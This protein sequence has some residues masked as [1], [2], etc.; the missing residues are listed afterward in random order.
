[1]KLGLGFSHTFV[2]NLFFVEVLRGLLVRKTSLPFK[3]STGSEKKKR[4]EHVEQPFFAFANQGNK[5]RFSIFL[6]FFLRKRERGCLWTQ[7]GKR[8]KEKKKP[9]A[10]NFDQMCVLVCRLRP[11]F[12]HWKV[13]W[14]WKPALKRTRVLSKTLNLEQSEMPSWYSEP[15]HCCEKIVKFPERLSKE[16]CDKDNQAADQEDDVKL[17]KEEH[18]AEKIADASIFP[19]SKEVRR[20]AQ[21]SGVE[22]TF[23]TTN[24]DRFHDS[25]K[26]LLPK[27]TQADTHWRVE[28]AKLSLW[29][30]P[31]EQSETSKTH[32]QWHGFKGRTKLAL[33][34]GW[35][36]P[37]Q[38][39]LS[40]R[41]AGWHW[42]N[43]LFF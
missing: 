17:P 7:T 31:W 30:R 26:D 29:E 37:V 43:M 34:T 12:F 32:C 3:I 9:K 22:S 28:S 10:G 11:L 35:T 33:T 36:C 14:S 42:Y 40:T 39:R 20:I 2:L 24:W 38:Y 8:K 13:S 4:K 16:I 19:L 41:S 23:C 6:F 27:E 15:Q 21:A 25:A 1:M 5:F 18:E